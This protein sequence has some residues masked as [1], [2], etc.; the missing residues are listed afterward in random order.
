[1][2]TSCCPVSECSKT[3]KS[4]SSISFALLAG[5][6]NASQSPA[7]DIFCA[8]TLCTERN[9]FTIEI[10]SG[11]GLTNASTYVHIA[12]RT[13]QQDILEEIYKRIDL[14][15]GK[16]LSI[17]RAIW[18]RNI[19]K[20]LLEPGHVILN[21]GDAQVQ[22]L[23]RGGDT[24]GD[25]A[26]GDTL[27]FLMHDHIA[28]YRGRFDGCDARNKEEKCELEEDDHVYSRAKPTTS[29]HVGRKTRPE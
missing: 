10:D 7:G 16:M 24:R 15:L 4:A 27:A 6:E 13:R 23:V 2:R 12:D 26:V 28:E 8:V 3:W 19:K 17:E 11:L 20:S 9:W 21:E 25:E 14:L 22:Y 5:T 18:G 29:C 1:M